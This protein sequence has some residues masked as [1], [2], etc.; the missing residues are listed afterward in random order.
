MPDH[1]LF[2]PGHEAY[3]ARVREFARTELAPRSS[4]WDRAAVL[5]REALRLL[6]DHGLLGIVAPRSRGGEERD[7][8]SLGIAIEEIAAADVSCAQIAWIQNTIGHFFP[9]WGEDTL[10]AVQR[11]EAAIALATSEEDAGSDVSAMKTTA[12]LDGDEYVIDGSKIHV[13]LTPGASVLAVSCR[14]PAPDGRRAIGMLRVP[15]DAP[16]VTIAPMEQ[17][18]A[19]AHSLGAVRLDRVRVPCTATLGAQN[20]GKALMYARYNV[21]RCLS[22]LAA[23]GAAGDVLRR[24]MDFARGKVVFGR[25]IAMNQSV[26]FPLVEHQAK[27]EAGRLLC[28]RALWMNDQGLDA[29]TEAAMAKWFGIGAGIDA[30]KDCLPLWGANGYLKEFPIE[31]KLRDVLSLNFTGGTLNIMRVLL[32]RQLLGADFAGLRA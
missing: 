12:T 13:S 31:Q 5:P 29:S 17:M 25:P 10:R 28:Y 3:R 27:V 20:E 23:L 1:F 6:G 26:S 22:P 21:S 4:E 15:A 7:Y 32:V 30:V 8:V 14:M 24:T 19:R 16:G 11:G 2:T 18:G 9:G